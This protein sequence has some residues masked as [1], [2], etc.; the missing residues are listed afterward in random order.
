[1]GAL[2]T[3]NVTVPDRLGA[4]ETCETGMV[5]TDYLGGFKCMGGD[6]LENVTSDEVCA[7]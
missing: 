2:F 4:Y 6:M 7:L 5:W 1:M 3:D